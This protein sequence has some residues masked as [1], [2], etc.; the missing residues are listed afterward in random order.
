MLRIRC[1][2]GKG[3]MDHTECL[4]CARKAENIC[5]MDYSL[6]ASLYN[7]SEDRSGEIHV[8]D[9]LS[10][11]RKVYL[12]K[13]QPI[14]VTPHEMMPLFKGLAVHDRLEESSKALPPYPPVYSELPVKVG[15]L[16]GRI[17]LAYLTDENKWRLLDIKTAK[18]LYVSLVP[19]GE[20]E[21]QTN[22]YAWMLKQQFGMNIDEIFI[23]YIGMSG[24]TQCKK[25]RTSVVYTP[26][27]FQCPSCEKM[28]EKGHLGVM[29]VPIEKYSDDE[30]REV[31]ET[32]L[33]LIK[34]ALENNEL[35]AGSPGW[36][37][38][39]CSF[40]CDMRNGNLEE[41]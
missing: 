32:R 29:L 16:V 30:V 39:F 23:Q 5:G 8:T 40:E 2:A 34:N 37:C 20:H 18:E 31:V 22:I 7:G 17:D 25:C 36:L 41:E 3:E 21:T 9:L 28:F 38:K 26:A 15:E 19:Y 13:T 14:A 33:A 10:C 24:P 12:S 27:G 4:A 6:L 1:S 35:P 11:P